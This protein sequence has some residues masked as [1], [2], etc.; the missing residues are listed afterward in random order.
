[1]CIV[2]YKVD[3][4]IWITKKAAFRCLD[5]FVDM[6]DVEQYRMS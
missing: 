1:M 2:R 6:V 3:S 4:G 5:N